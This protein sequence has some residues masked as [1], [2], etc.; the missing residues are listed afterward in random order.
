MKLLIILAAGAPGAAAYIEANGQLAGKTVQFHV[1]QV[2]VGP[3]SSLQGML[4]IPS[5]ISRL[6][7]MQHAHWQPH[8][9]AQS[10]SCGLPV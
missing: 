4:H 8:N 10:M 2:Q 5:W 6:H 9:Y 1:T 3:C 7:T